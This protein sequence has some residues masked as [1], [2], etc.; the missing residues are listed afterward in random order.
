MVDYNDYLAAL[1]GPESG[2]DPT[3]RN[4]YSGAQGLYQ[5]MPATQEGLR[6][7]GMI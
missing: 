2:R 6:R 7:Q 1:A 5:I 3:A 4:R